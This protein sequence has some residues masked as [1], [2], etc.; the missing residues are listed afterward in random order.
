[1]DRRFLTSPLTVTTGHAPTPIH[2]RVLVVAATP[3]A[4]TVGSVMLQHESLVRSV[5]LRMLATT[6]AH[7]GLRAL[8][9]PA[10]LG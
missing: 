5:T 6:P 8:R 2:C 3:G 10:V 7:H 4:S 1:M 9:P